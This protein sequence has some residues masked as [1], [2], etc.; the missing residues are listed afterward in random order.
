[1]R[2]PPAWRHGLFPDR[3]TAVTRRRH[4]TFGLIVGRTGVNYEVRNGETAQMDVSRG[5]IA[6]LARGSKGGFTVCSFCRTALA[7][8]LCCAVGTVYA[9]SRG[10]NLHLLSPRA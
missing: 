4:D 10:V 1:M 7:R 8:H 6:R 5:R 3:V 2:L 9:V